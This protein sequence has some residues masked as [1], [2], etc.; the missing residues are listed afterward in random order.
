ME[1][2]SGSWRHTAWGCFANSSF[3]ID[4]TEPL[5]LD[6]NFEDIA[7]LVTERQHLKPFPTA[8]WQLLS[9]QSDCH[10]WGCVLGQFV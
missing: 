6:H 1:S 8:G 10:V 2:L 3:Q 9:E 4:K 5:E 7:V